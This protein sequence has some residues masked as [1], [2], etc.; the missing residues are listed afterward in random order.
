MTAEV[1]AELAAYVPRG[2]GHAVCSS[3]DVF[4]AGRSV[5]KIRPGSP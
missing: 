4:S 1:P 2:S 5:V 3:G